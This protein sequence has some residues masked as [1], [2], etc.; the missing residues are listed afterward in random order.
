MSHIIKKPKLAILGEFDA[1]EYVG[2]L[3]ERNDF[4]LEGVLNTDSV[5]HFDIIAFLNGYGSADGQDLN[6]VLDD[7]KPAT[8]STFTSGLNEDGYFYL[9]GDVDFDWFDVLP[10]NREKFGFTGDETT[11]LVSGSFIMTATNRWKRGVFEI[12]RGGPSTK[13]G[14]GLSSGGTNWDAI[15]IARR[16]QNLPTYLRV[17]GSTGDADDVYSGKCLEDWEHTAGNT[18]MSIVLEEDGR[19]SFNYPSAYPYDNINANGATGESLLLRLGFDGTETEATTF[20]SYVQLRGTNPAPCVLT[21]RGYVELR[22]EVSGRDD[23]T[24][25]ADGSTVSG[26]LAPIKGWRVVVRVTG[27]AHGYSADR[28][29]HLRE[30]WRYARRG[31]TLYPTFGDPDNDGNGGNDTRRH[32]DLVSLYGTSSRHTLFQTV[33]ADESTNHFGKRVGGRLLVRRHPQDQQARRE[34]Y[35]YELDIHQDIMLRLS[36]DPAR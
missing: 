14:L 30:W 21:T 20:G 9:E 4:E 31:L 3:Y 16:V 13:L 7:N 29:R 24:I 15:P 17:R 26:G 8:F 12:E 35:A 27:P 32:V 10:D 1:T 18:Y 28:E 22:R 2:A 23:Y 33:E 11:S 34:D 25:M 36:D 6:S 5:P 19:V